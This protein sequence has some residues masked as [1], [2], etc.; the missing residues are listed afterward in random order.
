MGERDDTAGELRRH[1]DAM[2]GLGRAMPGTGL[3]ALG[4]GLQ[5]SGPW[6]E[7]LRGCP[8][9]VDTDIGGDA[10]DAL[11]VA[12]AA[13]CVPQ[14]ALVVTVDETG[15]RHGHGQR[16]RFAR[17]LLD[18]AGRPE[19]PVVAGAGTGDTAY[20]CVDG[21][22]PPGVPEQGR[23]VVAAVR[24]VCAA[25]D[26]PVRWV[27]MGPMSNLAQVIAQAPEL[28]S[29]L[30]VTQM[31][32]A[33]RY[34]HPDR[35]E[36]NIRLDVPAAR[37]VLQAVQ[38]KR[39]AAPEFVTSEVTFTPSL[40]VTA[41]SP[42]YRALAA[43]DAPVW[44]RILTGHMDRW[45]AQFHPGTIQ[46]DALTLSAALE[47]PFVDSDYLRITMDDIGRTTATADGVLVRVSLTAAYEA[48]MT[49]LLARL[50]PH[51]PAGTGTPIGAGR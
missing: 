24:A 4:E 39:V 47:L 7:D 36:H 11:A 49:W 21:L 2:V 12:V 40:E 25:A 23:D 6:P 50:D 5:A 30:R 19:V 45:F 16:A 8:L 15:E 3:A 44:A 31:G 46:H 20:Y 9:I 43:P 17:W 18:A 10:D 38:D 33:L 28:A 26:G 1:W 41:A 48:F 13:R 27:G 42:L 35:A 32:G 14:L 37:A 51:A 34:R 29:R 22:I